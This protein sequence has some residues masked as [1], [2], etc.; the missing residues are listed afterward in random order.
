MFSINFPLILLM[1]Y[2]LQMIKMPQTLPRFRPTFLIYVRLL[3]FSFSK[4]RLWD[5]NSK[6]S[7]KI[8]SFLFDPMF[9][10]TQK[11]YQRCSNSIFPKIFF[12]KKKK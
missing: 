5:Q 2:F 3:H 8:P 6:N 4:K 7:Q 11:N 10:I 9:K 12:L 1:D